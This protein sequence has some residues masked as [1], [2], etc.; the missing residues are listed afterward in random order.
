MVRESNNIIQFYRTD[1]LGRTPILSSLNLG[2]PSI[3]IADGK[4][5]FKN[6]NNDLI[7]FLN[8][9]Y[10]SDVTTLVRDN[11][12]A[13]TGGT[14]DVVVNLQSSEWRTDFQ[15]NSTYIGKALPNTQE[16]S[17]SWFIKKITNNENGQV[18]SNTSVSNVSWANRFTE[19]Y[20]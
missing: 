20:N 6:L 4:L 7:T 8:D 13:W 16:N 2:E 14:G 5:F 3:N 19:T 12:A 10:Y 15:N 9:S 1:V 11:S 17:S 18:I